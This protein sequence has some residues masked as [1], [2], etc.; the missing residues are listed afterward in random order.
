[1]SDAAIAKIT[2]LLRPGHYDLLYPKGTFLPN[3]QTLKPEMV[4]RYLETPYAMLY[5]F[6]NNLQEIPK[7][8]M[9]KL[10]KDQLAVYSCLRERGVMMTSKLLSSRIIE[11]SLDYTTFSSSK[12]KEQESDEG[13]DLSMIT[14][15]ITIEYMQS[16]LADEISED[17]DADSKVFYSPLQRESTNAPRSSSLTNVLWSR[18]SNASNSNSGEKEETA[19]CSISSSR[20][21]TGDGI[22]NPTIKLKRSNSAIGMIKRMFSFS[23]SK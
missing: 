4:I 3:I 2:V 21:I 20:D 8:V 23:N 22:G 7:S 1:V 5:L 12:G 16:S 10:S 15:I 18:S 19:G 9:K 11:L 6:C 13:Q 17:S 14:D